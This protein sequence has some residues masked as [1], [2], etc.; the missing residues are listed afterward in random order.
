MWLP[1]R[2]A[3]ETLFKVDLRLPAATDQV[4]DAAVRTGFTARQEAP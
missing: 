4:L 1:A 2:G 3:P